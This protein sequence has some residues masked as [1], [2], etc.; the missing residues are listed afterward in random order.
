LPP[1]GVNERGRAAECRPPSRAHQEDSVTDAIPEADLEE[2]SLEAR[3]SESDPLREG[4]DESDAVDRLHEA[5]AASVTG[6]IALRQL[7]DDVSEADAIEQAIPVGYDDE[8]D[9]RG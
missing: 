2:R 3:E 1:T 9:W 7:P 6:Q 5:E 8:D 4:V